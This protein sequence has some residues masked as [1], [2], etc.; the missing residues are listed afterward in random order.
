MPPPSTRSMLATAGTFAAGILTLFTTNGWRPQHIFFTV[1]NHSGGALH[2]VK[3]TYPGDELNV[4]T[5]PDS[6]INGT[7]RNFD[8]PGD[9]IVSYTTESG[10]TY[11]RPGPHVTGDEKGDVKIEIDGSDASFE[12]S[13]DQTQK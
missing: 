8:G 10:R 3:V 4:G 7:Y 6:T 11:T 1:S 5:L 12:T 13:F 9:L 2:D